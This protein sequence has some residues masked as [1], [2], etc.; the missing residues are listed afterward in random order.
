MRE[1]RYAWKRA[2]LILLT[3]YFLAAA[4]ISQKEHGPLDQCGNRVLYGA[5][6]S[7]LISDA[8]CYGR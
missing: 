5:G 8:I 3:Y 6:A 2:L 7:D 1:F 4:F